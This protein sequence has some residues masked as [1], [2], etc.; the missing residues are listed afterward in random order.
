[1]ALLSIGCGSTEYKSVKSEP[2]IGEVKADKLLKEYP[3][4]KA[5]YEAYKP[6]SEEINATKSLAG[7][8]IIVLFGSWCHDSEREVPRLLKL[9]DKSGVEL[10]ALSLY[11]LNYNKQEPNKLHRTYKV[12]FTPTIILFDSEQELGR[13]IEKP[14]INLAEDL[15]GFL[16]SK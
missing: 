16:L 12:N 15:A 10:E 3:N 1:M 8:S 6:T 13:I 14:V 7:K 4:F 11:G 5:I 2:L 9:L